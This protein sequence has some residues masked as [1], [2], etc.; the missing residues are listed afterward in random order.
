M[1]QLM[2]YVDLCIANEEDAADVFG[3][4]AEATNI[5]SG[6][7]NKEGYI[8]VAR[9]LQERF[10]LKQVA[11]T[12]RSS[13][14]A[15]DNNWSAPLYENGKAI[16]SRDY[17]IHIVDRVGGGDSF[18]AGLIYS[19]LA[20]FSAEN[21]IEFAVAASCLKHSIEGDFNHVSVDEV[22]KLAHGDASGRV[23]R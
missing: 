17:S 1:T 2:P 20:G 14:S 15:S 11:I 4:H 12:L 8:S 13:L 19:H 6:E 9:Q 7:L 16:F 18:S 21:S 22:L 23:S 3:I 10:S 5:T